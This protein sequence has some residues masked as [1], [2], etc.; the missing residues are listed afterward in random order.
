MKLYSVLVVSS[1]SVAATSAH[2][3][4]SA[5]QS[6]GGNSAGETCHIEAVTGI[7]NTPGNS[8]K[9]RSQ[10]TTDSPAVY[11]LPYG[12]EI[13][14]CSQRG[15]WSFGRLDGI[16]GWVVSRYL[17]EASGETNDQ[18]QAAAGDMP[19]DHFSTSE[20]TL[21][22]YGN[23]YQSGTVNG[24]FYRYFADG[25][26]SISV[27]QNI[28]SESLWSFRCR[29]DA[30]TDQRSCS[31]NDPAAGI[32]VLALTDD[33]RS[34]CAVQHDYPGR[35]AMVRVDKLEPIDLGTSGC[36]PIS[37]VLMGELRNGAEIAVRAYHW[38]YDFPKDM[39]VTLAGF[40]EAMSLLNFLLRRP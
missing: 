40:N 25:S 15:E 34:I 1:L 12:M 32:A 4:S 27:G 19:S 22:E 39:R 28:L 31:F 26:G 2:T 38:P 8:L 18:I 14:I 5:A 13:E 35:K 33:Q 24:L 21:S 7:K 37:D 11:D 17:G 36:Q 9:L 6:Q 29:T 16:E 23:S 30:M 3:T 10:P 20:R